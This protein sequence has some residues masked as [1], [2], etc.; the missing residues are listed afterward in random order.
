MA[1]LTIDQLKVVRSW[2]GDLPLESTLH[3]RYSRLNDL[4]GVILE[5]LR[6]QL[7]TLLNNPSSFSA[8]GV[9]IDY[10]SNISGLKERINDF[11]SKGG[12]G[13]GTAPVGG[14]YKVGVLTRPERR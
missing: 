11:V 5:E 2:V 13:D 4:D 14:S 10:G 3:E 1:E 7:S 8:E 9:S 6:Y 12:V